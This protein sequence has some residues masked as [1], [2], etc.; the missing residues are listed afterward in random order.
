[1]TIKAPHPRPC[2]SCPYRKDVPS[3]IWDA[4][5]Y[6]KLPA[7][8]EPTPYQP[9]G[10]FMCHQGNGHVCSGWVGC[11]DM[12]NTLAMRIAASRHELDEATIDAILDY[13]SPVEL[14]ASGQEAADHGL[15]DVDAPD[16][17]AQRLIGKLSRRAVKS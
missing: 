2:E 4:S 11:H 1:M 13:E 10:V 9:M 3:G 16:G 6:R 15:A 5:E 12:N 8:D 14:W 17:D 7:Y